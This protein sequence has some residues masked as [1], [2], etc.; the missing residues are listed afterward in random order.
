MGAGG[1][2]LMS[3]SGLGHQRCTPG[4][5]LTF[6]ERIGSHFPICFQASF[7][8]KLQGAIFM[9]MGD[10]LTLVRLTFFVTLGRTYDFNVFLRRFHSKTRFSKVQRH[11]F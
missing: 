5:D 10:M 9:D 4:N 7:S 2:F 1:P 3:K 11:Q 8:A 6:W